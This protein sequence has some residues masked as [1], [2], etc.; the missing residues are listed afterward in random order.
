MIV[1]LRDAL[2]EASAP[3]HD[4]MGINMTLRDE[5]FLRFFLS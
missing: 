3:Q 5:E 4:K 2:A 1:M